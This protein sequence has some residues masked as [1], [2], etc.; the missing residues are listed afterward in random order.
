MYM[1]F[2]EQ[3]IPLL[4]L[5]DQQ[6][7]ELRDWLFICKSDTSISFLNKIL[8]FL[9]TEF[10]HKHIYWGDFFCH[11]H[12]HFGSGFVC[13]LNRKHAGM[14]E[15]LNMSLSAAF[16]PLVRCLYLQSQ[17]ICFL[18]SQLYQFQ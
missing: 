9:W 7:Q 8:Q 14:Q 4:H 18:C 5:N 3:H 11:T 15:D 6:K 1:R 12:C 17:S 13:S 2:V 16:E 10:G